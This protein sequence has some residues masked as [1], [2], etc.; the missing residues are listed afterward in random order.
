MTVH[1]KA[2]KQN[3]QVGDLVKANFQAAKTG[4]LR[5][6]KQFDAERKLGIVLEVAEEVKRHELL[7]PFI[8]CKIEWLSGPHNGSTQVMADFFLIKV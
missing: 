2:N 6:H 3:L 7:G 8:Q 4:S 1:Q 5:H